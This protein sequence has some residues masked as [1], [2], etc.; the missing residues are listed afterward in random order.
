MT[1]L[2]L[3]DRVA[4][5]S[6]VRQAALDTT[7]IAGLTHTFYRYPARFSPGF[8]QTCIEAYSK[9]G[10]LVLD[11]Y[12]GGGTTIVEAMAA[13]RRSIGSDINEL[14]A[15]IAQVKVTRLTEHEERELS[16]WSES[17]VPAQRTTTAVAIEPD[18][19]KNMAMPQARWLKKTIGIL[20]SSVE[21]ELT[22]PR[23]RDFARCVILN[24][25]QWALNGRR[26]VVSSSAF[27]E[28]VTST[29]TAML[30]SLRSF[31]SKLASSEHKIH[32]PLIRVNDAELI[33]LDKKIAQA[34]L[35]NLVVTSPPY[36]GIHMLY[37]RWQVDGR[38]ETDAPYWIANRKDGAGA[39]HYNF[40]DRKR[41][42]EIDYY[43]KAAKTF[44]ATQKLMSR[45]ALLVQMVAFSE[46]KRQLPLY[47]AMMEC[48]GF[49][50]IRDAFE[51]RIWRDVPS[52]SWHANSK[53]QTS[54]SREVVLLH[55]AV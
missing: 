46:P 41:P 35:A 5:K 51:R 11:P 1:S 34:G 30:A 14:A 4:A 29:A 49:R 10:D 2:N 27:R 45:G 7:R 20:L 52:R 33:G 9:T 43:V 48:A 8:A 31:E 22:T 40:A 53:G 37:H 44:T 23:A 21:F 24:T 38:K 19:L 36:P 28:R 17:I 18:V 50:E 16:I 42:A 32:K 26:S 39:S 6:L 13:G 12:M 15:F 25:G 47:L 3:T 54:S 55:E